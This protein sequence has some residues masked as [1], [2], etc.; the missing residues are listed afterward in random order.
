[1]A[2]KEKQ[3]LRKLYQMDLWD[4]EEWQAGNPASSFSEEFIDEVNDLKE[5]LE[6]ES[7]ARREENMIYYR[8]EDRISDDPEIR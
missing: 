5:A 3:I 7:Q 2:K 4:L 1:M 6:C 8:Q